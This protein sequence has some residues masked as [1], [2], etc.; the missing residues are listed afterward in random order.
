MRD[1]AIGRHDRGRGPFGPARRAGVHTQPFSIIDPIVGPCPMVIFSPSLSIPFHD[2]HRDRVV[3]IGR[4]V[5]VVAVSATKHDFGRDGRPVLGDVVVAVDQ[6][7][8]VT[9]NVLVR[10]SEGFNGAIMSE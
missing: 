10:Q 6:F 4:V 9:G 5:V 3:Q 1:L 2:R 7:L 8:T